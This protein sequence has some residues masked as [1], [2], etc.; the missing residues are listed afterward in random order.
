MVTLV[1]KVNRDQRVILVHR[2]TMSGLLMETRREQSP[3]SSTIW[4]PFKVLRVLRVTAASRVFRVKP[5]RL[6]NRDPRVT[7]V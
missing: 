5:V 3:T 7:L 1:L 2:L 6:V 4:E